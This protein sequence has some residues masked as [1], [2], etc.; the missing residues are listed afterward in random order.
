MAVVVDRKEYENILRKQF[1][2][3][4]MLNNDYTLNKFYFKV[5]KGKKCW[6]KDTNLCLING[7]EAFGIGNWQKIKIN[8][9]KDWNKIEI[10]L[11]TCI[12]LGIQDL[13]HY[14]GKRLTKEEIFD[15]KCNNLK[16][17]KNVRY[18]I[19]FNKLPTKNFK[20]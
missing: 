18:N 16:D 13:T 17:K 9:L 12:L 19:K 10:R 2:K 15:E 3:K 1:V 6:T 14:N 4:E 5:E 20:Y 11:H 7:I 8:Y